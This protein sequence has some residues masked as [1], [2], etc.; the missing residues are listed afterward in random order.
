MNK[1]LIDRLTPSLLKKL[2]SRKI[3]NSEAANSLNVSETYLSR[4]VA[5]LQT[6]E[7]G[8][9]RIER[10]AA[11]TLF[12]ARLNTR[13]LLAKEV[14]KGTKTLAKA[15]K[16][17]NCSERTMLRWVAKYRRKPSKFARKS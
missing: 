10:E 4:V 11:K 13:A 17:A 3:T 5:T 6:K 15:C 2:Q 7:P 8:K 14:I 9:T 16:S 12:K 1:P